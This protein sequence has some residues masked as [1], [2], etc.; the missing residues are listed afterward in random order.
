MIWFGKNDGADFV[1]WSEDQDIINLYDIS[2]SDIVSVDVDKSGV[3]LSFNTG[4]NLTI[5]AS[6][7]YTTNYYNGSQTTTTKT[8]DN[9]KSSIFQLADSSRWQYNFST[10]EWQG[11]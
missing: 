11:A 9:G 7:Y 5:E 10:S 8:W 3:S 6:T 4:A 1:K 2:L